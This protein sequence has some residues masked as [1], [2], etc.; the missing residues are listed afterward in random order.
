VRI[1]FEKR[2]HATTNARHDRGERR[3]QYNK[4]NNV[5]IA[6]TRRP[7]RTRVDVLART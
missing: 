2:I 6:P 7:F 5:A 4:K 3:E 1:E